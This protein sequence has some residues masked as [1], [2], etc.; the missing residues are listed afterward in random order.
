MRH[1]GLYERITFTNRPVTVSIV[2]S[3]A[4]SRGPI[5]SYGRCALTSS[6]P[7]HHR[8]AHTASTCL[9]VALCFK[10]RWHKAVEAREPAPVTHL[11]RAFSQ[12]SSLWRPSA[13]SATFTSAISSCSPLNGKTKTLARQLIVKKKA[14]RPLHTHGDTYLDLCPPTNQACCAIKPQCR[15]AYSISMDSPYM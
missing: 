12:K 14:L 11:H 3:F 2:S 1:G 9:Y 4:P 6:A 5:I 7:L 13:P 15:G 8:W 10:Q